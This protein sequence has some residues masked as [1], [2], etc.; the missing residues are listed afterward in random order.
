MKKYIFIGIGGSL[1]AMLRFFLENI[2]IYHYRENIPLN[3]LI[4][5]VT[6]SFL[7]ALIMTVA[8]EIWSIDADIRIG[9][10]TGFMGAFT[11]F[12]TLCKEIVTLI[13]KGEYFSALSY[14]TMSIVLGLTAIYYGIVLAREFVSKLIQNGR[15]EF[16]E[17][18]SENVK[19]DGEVD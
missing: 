11:T 10:T 3:T 2:H 16:N 19:L 6:G 1:G 7:L 8:L 17:D 13:L 5:N 14:M 4:I 9:I 12:S 15:K 18:I